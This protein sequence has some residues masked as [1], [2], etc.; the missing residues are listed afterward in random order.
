M[1]CPECVDGTGKMGMWCN[2]I[3]TVR[4]L[5]LFFSLQ[6]WTAHLVIFWTNNTICWTRT[7]TSRS[8]QNW[9]EIIRSEVI[10][11]RKVSIFQLFMI[12]SHCIFIGI[13]D[14]WRYRYI[15][16]YIWVLMVSVYLIV[17]GI[18]IFECRWYRY[19]YR[20]IWVLTVSV[21][22][23]VDGIGIY[24]GISEYWRYRYIWVLMVS[25]YISAYLSIDGIGIF[26]CRWYRYIYR[27][28]WVLTVS[29][30]D[31]PLPPDVPDVELEA[32]GLHGFDVEA[33]GRRYR[34]D[35]FTENNPCKLGFGV[36]FLLLFSS[37]K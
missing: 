15:Y 34:R 21:Y 18:G 33:L 37:M 36:F 14:C 28:I 16:R 17:D 23:S 31:F 30:P 35:I 26:E 11:S 8:F 13:S 19:I 1:S 25:V 3:G 5:T 20:H 24:I 29:V 10:A 9:D 32:L 7:W 4:K 6:L 2:Q 22:L 12:S 27:H